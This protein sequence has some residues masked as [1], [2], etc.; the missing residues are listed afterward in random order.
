MKWLVMSGLPLNFRYYDKAARY[1]EMV[2][3]DFLSSNK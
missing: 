2:L 3:G 1:V